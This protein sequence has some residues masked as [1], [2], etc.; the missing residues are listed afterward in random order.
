M[1][2]PTFMKALAAIVF[3]APLI[4]CSSLDGSSNAALECGEHCDDPAPDAGGAGDAADG[5]TLTQGYWKNH[6]EA[7]PVS[8]LLLGNRTYAKAELLVILR[9]PVKGNGLI[10]LAHQLIAAKLNIAAGASDASIAQV[11]LD[12]DALIGNLVVGEAEVK[13]NVTSGLVGQLDAF[14][15]GNIGPGHCDDGPP[16]GGCDGGGECP[17][18]PSCGNGT[19]EDGEACDDGNTSSGDGCSEACTT[20]THQCVCGDGILDSQ[21]GEACDDGNTTSGDGCSAS[22][23]VEPAAPV[24]GNDVVEDGEACDDGNLNDHDGCS[25]TCTIE[26]NPC[27]PC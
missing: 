27:A 20:E 7:W 17:Q 10:S 15:N 16:G 9:T 22:C 21:H 13:T 14:N 1:R 26:T 11:I 12:A 24:C 3:A 6:E 4:H 8:S 5:C 19:V 23:T 2:I 25:P 18:P